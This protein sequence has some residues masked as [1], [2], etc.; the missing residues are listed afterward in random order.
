MDNP[1][2]AHEP[3]VKENGEVYRPNI[4]DDTGELWAYQGFVCRLCHAYYADPDVD[5]ING[6]QGP[7]PFPELSATSVCPAKLYEALKGTVL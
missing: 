4:L 3:A 5:P 1:K 2:L 7:Q 6:R